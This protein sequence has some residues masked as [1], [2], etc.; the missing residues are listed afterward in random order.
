MI[1]RMV[2]GIQPAWLKP[3]YT[4]IRT[5]YLLFEVDPEKVAIPEGATK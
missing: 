2:E 1:E 4:G 5:N 3:V